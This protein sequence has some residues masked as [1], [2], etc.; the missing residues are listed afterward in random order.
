MYTHIEEKMGRN[1]KKV[2]VLSQ[3]PT[4]TKFQQSPEHYT[5][6]TQAAK[7]VPRTV[8]MRLMS[9]PRIC[10]LLCSPRGTFGVYQPAQSGCH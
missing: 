2:V 4:S 1:C 8:G 9:I 10:Q 6:Y 7:Q 5:L 3:T